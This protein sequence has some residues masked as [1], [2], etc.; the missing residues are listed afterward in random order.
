MNKIL[1][2]GVRFLRAYLNPIP[3]NYWFPVAVPYSSEQ[4]KEERERG[5]EEERE[6]GRRGG[7]REKG[8]G[9]GRGRKTDTDA[10][11]IPKKLNVFINA[12]FVKHARL[13]VEYLI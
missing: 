13:W 4:R 8:E 1:N 6:R 12:T 10:M 9:R 5:Q 3:N 11:G 2:S 7:G